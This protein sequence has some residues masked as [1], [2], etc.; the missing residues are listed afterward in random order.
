MH[1][2]AMT[3]HYLVLTEFPFVI[4]PID[5]FEG[6]GSFIDHFKWKPEQGTRFIVIERSTGKLVSQAVAEAFFC[7]HH[8]NAYESKDGN[9]LIDG[10]FYRYLYFTLSNEFNESFKM[11][12]LGKFDLETR[13]LTT[14]NEP[15]YSVL[16]PIFVP[17]PESQSED[18]GVIL[19]VIH[20][21]NKENAFLV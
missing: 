17:S 15:G 19:T 10:K 8:A 4:N 9:D 7:W 3:E 1:S 2:F 12:G 14:W 21:Q 16:E 20:D 11:T 13:V 6:S 5:L 18:D